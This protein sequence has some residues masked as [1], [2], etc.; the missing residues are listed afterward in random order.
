MVA[1]EG[2]NIANWITNNSGFYHLK[3]T[4]NN[5]YMCPKCG[6]TQSNSFS[7]CPECEQQ[8]TAELVPESKKDLWLSPNGITGQVGNSGNKQF[9][10]YANGNFGVTTDGTLYT[11]GAKISG[12]ITAGSININNNF[13]VDAQG[14][15]T[16]KKANIKGTITAT[17]GTIGNCSINTSGDLTVPSTHVSGNFD[18]GRISGGTLSIQDASGGSFSVGTTTTH[19][20]TTG[21]NVGS[22]G[23]AYTAKGLLLMG[24]NGGK[25]TIGSTGNNE[26]QLQS[27]QIY[28]GTT[29][30]SKLSVAGVDA[31]KTGQGNQSIKFL[32][33]VSLN[34][35]HL[36]FRNGILVAVTE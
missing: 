25:G 8:V 22:A 31:Y 36:V 12:D 27:S 11:K 28:L 32:P 3:P 13:I 17:S 24:D 18:A 1:N 20:T 15:L 10:F 30:S 34:P 2:S 7:T 5:V 16:A 35:K 23:I 29:S 4:G 6:Y 9:A 19:A 26:I 14:N 21:L 33:G